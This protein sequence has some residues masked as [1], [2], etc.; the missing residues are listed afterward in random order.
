MENKTLYTRCPTCNTAFKVTEKLLSMAEGKV[1]CGACLAIFQATDY[2]LSPSASSKVLTSD[3]TESNLEKAFENDS[4]SITNEQANEERQ[5]A[6]FEETHP[7]TE[8]PEIEKE[9]E[10]LEDLSGL[11]GES[12]PE[13]AELAEGSGLDGEFEPEEEVELAEGVG[14]EGESEPEEEAELAEESGLDAEPGLEEELELAEESDLVE[15]PE[16]YNES[17][18]DDNDPKISEI[19]DD[20]NRQEPLTEFDYENQAFDFDEESTDFENDFSYEQAS[21]DDVEPFDELD[22]I[23]DLDDIVGEDLEVEDLEVEELEVE[24]LDGVDEVALDEP[25]R[26]EQELETKHDLDNEDG[27][28]R[29]DDLSSEYQLEENDYEDLSDQ[30]TEQMEE[31]D[32]EPDPLDEFDEVVK[33]NTA[34]IKSKLIVVTFSILILVGLQQ[35]WSNRQALAWSDNW[36]GTVKSVCEYLPCELKAKRD[37]SKIKLL[38][39]QL[40]PDDEQENL[41]DIKVLL[42]NEADFEQPYPTIKIVFS[43]QNG[44]QVAVKLFT[45]ENYLDIDPGKA[46]MPIGSEVHIGFKTEQAHPDALGFEFIFQ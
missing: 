17:D 13:E 14:L 23:T 45:P 9:T 18:L 35:I 19:D 22:D 4:T 43:N 42:I 6:T 20:L 36:G 25:Y 26:E 28:D 29:E 7:S 12:E 21:E 16:P 37:V 8:E 10:F 32:S 40:S 33:E 38:Q 2:M 44:E 11:D 46:L 3:S 24:E 15:E 5:E 30:L 31:T 27:L 39:R 41:L 34:G 1:R